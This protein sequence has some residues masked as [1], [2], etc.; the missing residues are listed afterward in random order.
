MASQKQGT[1][2]AYAEGGFPRL[3]LLPFVKDGDLIEMHCVRLDPT[4]QAL[5]RNP[6]VTFMV[7]DYLGTYP[8]EWVDPD[9]GGRG[10]T[11]FRAVSFDCLAEHDTDP[12]AVAAGLTKLL[13]VYEPGARHGT[14]TDGEVYGARL[15]QLAFVR[16]RIVAMQAKFK[17]GPPGPGE[18]SRRANVAAQLRKRGQPGDLEAARW[19]DH[20]NGLRRDDGSWPV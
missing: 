9:D 8:S 13:S 15:R 1:L 5:R 12:A 11:I 18:K 4:F 3:S 19:I 16:L 6:R 10:S 7:S 14:I 2:A 17:I 20:Y